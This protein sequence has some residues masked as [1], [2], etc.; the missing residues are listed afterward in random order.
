MTIK[1]VAEI[2]CLVLM[3]VNAYLAFRSKIKKDL[4]GMIWNLAFMILMGVCIS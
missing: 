3:V 4:S 2:M 1:I